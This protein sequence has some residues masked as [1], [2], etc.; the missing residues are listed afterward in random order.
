MCVVTMSGVRCPVSG[1]RCQVSGVSVKMFISQCTYF[2]P[3][4]EYVCKTVLF[5]VRGAVEGAAHGGQR[6]GPVLLP[7]GDVA[8]LGPPLLHGRLQYLLRRRRK[9]VEGRGRELS[10]VGEGTFTRRQG[11]RGRVRLL[12]WGY[13]RKLVDQFLRLLFCGMGEEDSLR[14]SPV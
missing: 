5:G 9:E 2:A 8:R 11:P 13:V 6:R 3:H 10:I 7:V 14:Q 4:I 1:V 12:M